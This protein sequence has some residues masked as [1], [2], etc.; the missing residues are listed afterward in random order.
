MTLY[1][2]VNVDGKGG[3]LIL[4]C[5]AGPFAGKT[6]FPI[7]IV[8]NLV[9]SL[10][11]GHCVALVARIL[12]AAKVFHNYRTL[13]FR[14]VMHFCINRSHSWWVSEQQHES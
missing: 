9:K 8:M 6:F 5:E 13:A 2:S 12:L 3:S 1:G 11:A 14:W 4:F 10:R 7:G